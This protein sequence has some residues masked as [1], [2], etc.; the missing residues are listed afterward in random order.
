MRYFGNISAIALAISLSSC[1]TL[2]TAFDDFKSG[3]VTSPTDMQ[4]ANFMEEV[5]T[6]VTIEPAIHYPNLIM[7]GQ[8]KPIRPCF[9]ISPSRNRP[10]HR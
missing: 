4:Q 9:Y 7:D 3:K 6:D 2:Q 8:M 1:A 10:R 5:E